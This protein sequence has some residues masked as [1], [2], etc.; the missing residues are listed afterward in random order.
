MINATNLTLAQAT[1]LSENLVNCGFTVTLTVDGAWW[2]LEA[3]NR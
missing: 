2:S 1:A 3:T